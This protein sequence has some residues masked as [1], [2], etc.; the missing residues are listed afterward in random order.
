ML[1]T[2]KFFRNLYPYIVDDEWE[3]NGNIKEGKMRNPNAKEKTYTFNPDSRLENQSLMQ[4]AYSFHTE[5]GEKLEFNGETYLVAGSHIATIWNWEKLD[6]SFLLTGL[7]KPK[8]PGWQPHTKGDGIDGDGDCV[9]P[10]KSAST[11]ETNGTLRKFYAKDVTHGE[12][13]NNKNVRQAIEIILMG[14]DITTITNA[15]RA[16]PDIDTN[17]F[18][19]SWWTKLFV[20]SPVELHI[21]DSWGNHIGPNPDRTLIESTPPA[22]YFITG[23]SSEST[24]A[25]IPNDRT[26]K[27]EIYGTEANGIASGLEDKSSTFGLVLTQFAG[28]TILKTMSYTNIEILPSS[29]G[30]LDYDPSSPVPPVLKLD[31]DGDGT[32]DKVITPA[33]YTAKAGARNFI[34]QS[35][36]I[37]DRGNEP[38]PTDLEQVCVAKTA[39]STLPDRYIRQLKLFHDRGT[40]GQFDP[41]L[42]WLR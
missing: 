27:I 40:I 24:T 17:P 42:S 32:I 19:V 18:G 20:G 15:V 34:I 37:R 12:L 30:T 33:G 1:P 6:K 5:M 25:F 35:F 39:A 26:Y 4:D 11:L 36:F 29:I 22:T 14:T 7:V 9:V 41:A 10:L 23:G 13:R 8:I 2:E 38:H 3:E 21:Y 31:I 16:L 28:G